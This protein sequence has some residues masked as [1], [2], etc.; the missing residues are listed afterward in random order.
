M[1][2]ASNCFSIA[3]LKCACA[4][5]R[6]CSWSFELLALL[7]MHGLA[8]MGTGTCGG[9]ISVILAREVCCS[10]PLM[11]PARELGLAPSATC[12]RGALP[13][14]AAQVAIS[15]APSACEELYGPGASYEHRAADLAPSTIFALFECVGPARVGRAPSE[16]EAARPLVG[17]ANIGTPETTE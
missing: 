3:S 10:P 13:A 4:T 14:G 17:V 15:R 11:L 8:I 9:A 6:P 1:R 2:G 5:R 16:L 12:S 7:V